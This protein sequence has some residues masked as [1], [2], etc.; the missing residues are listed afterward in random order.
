M[1]LGLVVGVALDIGVGMA[2]PKVAV[3]AR[4]L[5][6]SKVIFNAGKMHDES[7][8]VQS[9]IDTALAKAAARSERSLI[10]AS[11]EA[12]Q[13]DAMERRGTM[14]DAED[15]SDMHVS[16]LRN[17]F[18]RF[19][20]VQA[21]FN[22]AEAGTPQVLPSGLQRIVDTQRQQGRALPATPEGV[23]LEYR[24]FRALLANLQREKLSFPMLDA[25]NSGKRML[26][27]LS[28]ALQYLLPFD[29]A[30]PSPLRPAGR[31]HLKIPARFR[32]QVR[33]LQ[34]CKRLPPPTLSL[35][36]RL[37]SGFTNPHPNP[38]SLS[39]AGSKIRSHLGFVFVFCVEGPR[40]S[41]AVSERPLSE[42]SKTHGLALFL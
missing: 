5:V 34:C 42:R 2:S 20:K 28:Q 24:L 32:T 39:P 41:K 19:L 18:G 33:V 27:A 15:L 35:W 11:A 12:F 37:G 16:D 9:V 1:A 23:R 10:F 29:L 4:V 14:L 6:G 26:T 3:T 17:Q 25:E 36:E 21:Q 13:E 30:D 38:L 31:V 40:P 22:E 7:A 8:T